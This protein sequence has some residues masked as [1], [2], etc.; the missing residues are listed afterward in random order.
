MHS[1]EWFEKD[2]IRKYLAAIDAW[3]FAPFMAGYGKSGVPD[4]VACYRTMFIAI[5]VK[6]PG[7]EPTP[8]QRR[9]MAEIEAHGGIAVAGD[10]ETVIAQLKCLFP[11]GDHK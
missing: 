8:V 4:I 5:E 10:A 3:C 9:R 6:R 7:K 2:K 1:P 11:G